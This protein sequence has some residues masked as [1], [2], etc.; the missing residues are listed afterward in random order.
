[1]QNEIIHKEAENSSAEMVTIGALCIRLQCI[2]LPIHGWVALVN[3]LC[4][5]LGN[6]GGAM[7]L[8]TSRQGSCMIPIL[9]P[10]AHFFGAYGIASVQGI[11]DILSLALAIPISVYMTKKIRAAQLL[12]SDSTAEEG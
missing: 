5:G 6:A 7:L 1:M 3:M 10:L 4:A 9:F 11:A 12:H 2:A 8:S